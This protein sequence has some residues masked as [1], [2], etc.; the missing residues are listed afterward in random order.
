MKNASGSSLTEKTARFGE[1]IPVL[2]LTWGD[3]QGTIKTDNR[4]I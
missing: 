4:N 1:K 3:K 2:L